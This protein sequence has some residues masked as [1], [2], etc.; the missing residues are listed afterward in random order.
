VRAEAAVG[1][2]LV[3]AFD[4]AAQ[5]GTQV[6]SSDQ[7]PAVSCVDHP[8]CGQRGGSPMTRSAAFTPQ[9]KSR[10]V[11]CS[12]R[13]SRQGTSCSKRAVAVISRPAA[14]WRIAGGT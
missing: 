6:S 13:V 10:R 5:G 2:R 3:T 14:R 11:F 7:V 8:G 12:A 4:R 9:L 1:C